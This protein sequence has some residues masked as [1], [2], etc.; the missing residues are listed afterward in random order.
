MTKILKKCRIL[1]VQ[2]RPVNKAFYA[3]ILTRLFARVCGKRPEFC[4]SNMFVHHDFPVHKTPPLKAVHG[5]S[6]Y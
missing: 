4:P 2:T 1:F 5:Q 3:E 6:N